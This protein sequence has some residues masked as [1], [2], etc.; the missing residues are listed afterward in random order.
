MRHSPADAWHCRVGVQLPRVARKPPGVGQTDY[1]HNH[2]C[3]RL[4]KKRSG[5]TILMAS[6]NS[7]QTPPAVH[8]SHSLGRV[9]RRSGAHPRLQRHLPH[10]PW[11]APTP[12]THNAP[13]TPLVCRNGLARILPG[14]GKAATDNACRSTSGALL[15]HSIQPLAASNV[16][17]RSS[18][19][20]LSQHTPSPSQHPTSS[21]TA[22]SMPFAAPDLPHH[23]TLHSLRSTPCA[24]V[25]HETAC[26]ATDLGG[27]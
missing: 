10:Q 9:P 11:A 2:P 20:S 27:S 7:L 21:V 16:P 6:G 22:H 24:P 3:D 23:R 13:L 19:H 8:R 25:A 4:G 26:H 18:R 15:Q 14:E 5:C 12:A 17:R 1:S